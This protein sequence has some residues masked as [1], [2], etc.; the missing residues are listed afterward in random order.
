MNIDAT[1]WT[2]NNSDPSK[3]RIEENTAIELINLG[4]AANIAAQF[5]RNSVVSKKG[6]ITGRFGFTANSIYPMSDIY[7]SFGLYVD[8]NNRIEF[9][10]KNLGSYNLSFRIISAGVTTYEVDDVAKDFGKYEI[11]ITA[12]NLISAFKWNGSIWVQIGVN[13]TVALGTKCIF[14]ASCGGFISKLSLSYCYIKI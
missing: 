12:D 9:Y 3:V 2:V 6:S 1:K 4:T 13:Q 14:A 7:Q 8:D 11:V 10:R 5:N